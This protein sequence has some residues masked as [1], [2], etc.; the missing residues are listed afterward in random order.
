[1]N[2]EDIQ[3]AIKPIDNWTVKITLHCPNGDYHAEDAWFNLW[4]PYLT[5]P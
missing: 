5:Q 1:M 4:L 2:T 3:V